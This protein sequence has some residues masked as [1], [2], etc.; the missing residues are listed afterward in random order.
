MEKSSSTNSFII[1]FLSENIKKYQLETSTI[2]FCRYDGVP[3]FFHNNIG[4]SEDEA[5]IGALLGG[6]WQAAESLSR[7][8]PNSDESKEFRF[9]FDTASQGV[10]AIPININKCDYFLGMIYKN[11]ISPGKIKSKLRLLLNKLNKEFP[12]SCRDAFNT[13]RSDKKGEYLFKDIS[14]LEMDKLFSFTGN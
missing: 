10:Y 13:E 9:S 8:I 1:N 3:I 4:L 6:A 7:F 2:F 14:D 11:N 5:T 12:T